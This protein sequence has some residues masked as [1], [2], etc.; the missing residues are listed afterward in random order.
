MKL[1]GLFRNW[2]H[3]YGIKL[4]PMSKKTVRLHLR[5]RALMP[6]LGSPCNIFVPLSLQHMRAHDDPTAV[7]FEFRSILEATTR[8]DD[9]WKLR[10]RCLT[11]GMYS[12]HIEAWLEYFSYKQVGFVELNTVM[13]RV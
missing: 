7:Q 11:P 3:F 1:D 6:N 12:H 5:I 10:Q 2:T 13:P 9:V 4:R 8:G